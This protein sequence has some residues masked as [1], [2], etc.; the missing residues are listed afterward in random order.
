MNPRWVVSALV[1]VSLVGV[2]SAQDA[3]PWHDPSPHTVQFV[4][5]DK[6]V[7]LEVLDWGGSGRALVLLAGLGDTAH[8]FDDFA[9]KLTSQYHVCGIT[10]RGYGSSSAPVSGYSADRLGDDV[11]AVLDALKIE[12]P[13]VVGSSI[14][15]EE[16]SSVGTRHP[17]RVAGLVYLDAGFPY[18][19]YDRS[20]GDFIID[21]DE[22]KTKVDQILSG[23]DRPIQEQFVQELLQSILPAFGK[24]VQK[25]QENLAR[26]S[27]PLNF[28][29]PTPADKQSFAA[30]LAWQKKVYGYATPEAELRQ[31]KHNP[32]IDDLVMAGEQKYTNLRVPILAIFA[33]P[34]DQGP[35]VNANSSPAALAVAEANDMAI[36]GA[37]ATAFEAGV[38]SAH[39]VRLAHASH[40]VFLSNEGDV[41]RE[42]RTFLTGLK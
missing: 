5:V 42:M 11:L 27:Q 40:Y 17:E 41:L 28:P 14:A 22:L 39:V 31:G 1:L 8:V 10:R 21:W 3:A 36:A 35:Y 4:T 24:D 26:V 12:Q 18:A 13:V 33:V 16:L 15:G 38:P 6:D 23:V 25:M 37:L 32:K 9:P 29:V 34:H 2:L 7:K 30:R 19:Y 20:R